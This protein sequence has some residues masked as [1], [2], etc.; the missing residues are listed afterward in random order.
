[1]D[2]RFQYSNWLKRPLE[3]AQLEYAL[4]DV[5]YL[6]KIYPML[7]E[8]LRELS[9]LDWLREECFVIE[10]FKNFIPTEL[11]LLNKIAAFLNSEREMLTGL[12]LIKLR[13][14]VAQEKDVSRSKLLK[15]EIIIKLAR[16]QINNSVLRIGTT[17]EIQKIFNHPVAQKDEDNLIKAAIKNKAKRPRQRNEIFDLMRAQINEIAAKN[18]VSPSLIANSEDIHLALAGSK[19]SRLAKGWRKHL[20]A[21]EIA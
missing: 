4:S 12:R 18:K 14:K 11:A 2:K 19:K 21:K 3:P 1:M 6:S 17:E 9:K 13:E 7:S 16:G 8:N 20:I 15:D 10:K 5:V